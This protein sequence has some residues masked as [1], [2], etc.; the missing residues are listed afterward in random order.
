MRRG[1]GGGV[2]QRE[3]FEDPLATQPERE[4]E[5]SRTNRG[6]G[7]VCDG[8]MPRVQPKLSRARTVERSSCRIS[9]PWVQGSAGEGCHG[10]CGMPGG[11]S[12]RHDGEAPVERDLGQE[13]EAA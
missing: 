2:E 13:A 12:R 4:N 3:I 10:I 9:K 7:G 1:G 8:V 6:I 5:L 11:L